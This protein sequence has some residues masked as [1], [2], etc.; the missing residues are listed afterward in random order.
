MMKK[1]GKCAKGMLIFGIVMIALA[2]ISYLA[3]LKYIALYSF[4]SGAM[5]SVVGAPY[6]N[7][8]EQ[9]ALEKERKIEQNAKR[10]YVI[11]NLEKFKCIDKASKAPE[12]VYLVGYDRIGLGTTSLPNHGDD[13]TVSKNKV[14]VKK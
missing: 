9:I 10:N 13:A 5:F 1:L 11:D 6:V 4:I 7:G 14:K 3:G 8:A 12:E 2:G